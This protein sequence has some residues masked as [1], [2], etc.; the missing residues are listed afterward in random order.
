M[1]VDVQKFQG[2]RG[3]MTKAG[4]IGVVGLVAS[5]GGIAADAPS[6]LF[7]YLLAFS[8]WAGIAFAS[9]IMLM[10]FHAFRAKWM[11]VLRRPLE[12]MAVTVVLF[13]LL[14]IPI[15]TG[16][17]HIYPWVHPSHD[18][19][20]EALKLLEHKKPFLNVPFFLIRTGIYFLF[21]TL[22]SQ[23]L[24]GL[25]TRQDESGEVD[26]T[27]SQR[28][29]GVAGLPFMALVITFAA[30]DWMMSLN[31]LWFSTIFGVYYFAGSFLSTL[32]ILIIASNKAR[33]KD[34]F[35]D[36]VSVEHMHNLGKLL[37][38]FVC[39]WGYI[40]FSQLLLIWIANLPE[41]IPFYL[42][43]F[44]G[45][46]APVG[47]FL[48]FGHFFLPFGLLLSRQ[49]KRTPARLGVVAGW[50]LFVHFVDLYWLIVPTLSPEMPVF[51]W[52][53]ITSWLGIGGLATA[54]AIWRMRGR[55]ALPVK[56]PFLA[57]SL[58]Y[59]QP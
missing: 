44:K 11:V 37:F 2:G 23:R 9:L 58:R 52:T 26:L 12:A 21:A 18:L 29:T 32:A 33:G 35:G 51:P 8:Y 41:E 55:F 19:G 49:L 27:V 54:F 38:A 13:A 20:H 22:L 16:M 24:F 36:H 56:D 34:L 39:F 43:R 5:L 31:P 1:T 28:K 40:A 3:W 50:V 53:L 7:S 45:S 4:T 46:W 25:S 59:K 6:G 48:I 57:V 47:L 14:F 42:V 10:I 30:V 15:A 17:A